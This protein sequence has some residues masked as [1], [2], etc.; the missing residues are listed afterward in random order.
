MSQYEQNQKKAKLYSFISLPF[1]IL[2]IFFYLLAVI[3]KSVGE[4]LH[5]D[6]LVSIIV[7]SISIVIVIGI[8]WMRN[9]YI[10]ANMNINE[11]EA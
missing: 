2:A 10:R 3:D 6:R 7:G 5:I 8:M 9:K 1:F 4:N 11:Q